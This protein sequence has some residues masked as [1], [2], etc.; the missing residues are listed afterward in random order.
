[1]HVLTDSARLLTAVANAEFLRPGFSINSTFRM[2]EDWSVIRVR[3]RLYT[4]KV[5]AVALTGITAV[6]AAAWKIVSLVA[7][8]P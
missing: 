3:V 5:S 2:D 6:S 8:P 1:M 4:L 7:S